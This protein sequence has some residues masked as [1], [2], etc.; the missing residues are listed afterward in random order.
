MCMIVIFE[1]LLHEQISP[2]LVILNREIRN[3]PRDLI[4]VH[5]SM[6]LVSN[7]AWLLNINSAHN[8]CLI[9][10]NR[11]VY[12]PA[13]NSMN[14][15]INFRSPHASN[16]HIILNSWPFHFQFW[17]A[18]KVN[19]FSCLKLHNLFAKS[20]CS[21]NLN[22]E[23]HYIRS[24]S[25]NALSSLVPYLDKRMKKQKPQVKHTRKL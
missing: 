16:F 8:V 18:F 7:S 13:R 21:K 23:G 10:A 25:R 4:Q 17:S 14:L 11:S 19:S 15:A 12:P 1:T 3:S 22:I 6:N 2:R 5:T 24:G 9:P 20:V